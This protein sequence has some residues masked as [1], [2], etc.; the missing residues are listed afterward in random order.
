MKRLLL[1]VLLAILLAAC[2][3]ANSTGADSSRAD[4]RDSVVVV[5]S[6]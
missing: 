3:D 5:D 4:V 6:L 2:D 1:G